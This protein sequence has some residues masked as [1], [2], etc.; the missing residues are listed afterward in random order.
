[1]AFLIVVLVLLPVAGLVEASINYTVQNGDTLFLIAR[2][3]GTS[4]S[5]IKSANG[6]TGNGIYPGETL[7]IPGGTSMSTKYTVVRG[8]TLYLIAQ[9]FGIS[10]D[11][12]R[13]ANNLWKDT[14]YPGQVL[15]I[16]AYSRPAVTVSRGNPRRD[17]DL[18][19]RAVYAEARGEP[20]EGQVAVAAVILN[21]TENPNFPGTIQ[22]V[23]YEPGAFSCVDD[24]QIYLTP[25]A[26]AYKAAQDALNGWDPT[27]GSLYYWNPA[28]ATSKWVWTRTVIITIGNHVFAV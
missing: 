10:A 23:L 18:L 28:T 6:L 26:T 9:R 15:N 5:A 24:G 16:P 27:Y 7:V 4:V 12:I 22:G 20:Y 3:Y 8:D 25:D 21:R 17:I 19:A 14:V 13:S 11:S 1:M 2:R